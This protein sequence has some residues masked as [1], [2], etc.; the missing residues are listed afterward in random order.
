MTLSDSKTKAGTAQASWA[1]LP[2]WATDQDGWSRTIAGDVLKNRVQPSDLDI[3]RYLKVLLS[4]ITE[5]TALSNSDTPRAS[6]RYAPLRL[7]GKQ[8]PSCSLIND[9]FHNT[10][11]P[12][13]FSGSAVRRVML[14]GAASTHLKTVPSS[15]ATTGGHLQR[16]Y[17]TRKELLAHVHSTARTRIR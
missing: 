2:R 4:S 17:R 15:A 7:V 5:E 1:L 10:V 3:H 12:Y 13:P 11:S 6:A 16:L 9:S 8:I 14:R